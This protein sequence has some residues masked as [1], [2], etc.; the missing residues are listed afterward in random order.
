MGNI[1]AP[2]LESL[3]SMWSGP[4]GR[5]S[6]LLI[7][8]LDA[9]GKT[10][11]L[12]M[13]TLGEC[14]V[15][16]PTIGFNVETFRLD[17]IEFVA[18]DIGGQQSIRP[19][20]RCYLPNT[21]AVLFVVDSSDRERMQEAKNELHRLFRENE[22]ADARLLVYAN[23]QDLLG[24]MSVAEIREALALETVTRNASHV[25]ATSAITGEGICEGMAWLSKALSSS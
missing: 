10:T 25:Q 15:T 9:A 16:I 5:E 12:Y 24:A 22:L 8:G 6:R 7:L 13:L 4:Q 17:N 19:Y 3:Y 20:W 14:P 1:I 21:D 23:K 2:Y 11:L 18:W